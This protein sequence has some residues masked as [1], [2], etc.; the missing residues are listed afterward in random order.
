MA[1]EVRVGP[2]DGLPAES[3][4]SLDNIQTVPKAELQR[5]ITSLSPVK[6]REIRAAI[7]FAFGF[8]ELR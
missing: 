1:T 8:D 4:I 3:A 7:E 5:Q 2:G 6:L